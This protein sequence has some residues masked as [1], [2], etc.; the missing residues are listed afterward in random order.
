MGS[1]DNWE[2]KLSLVIKTGDLCRK[3]GHLMTLDNIYVNAN[4]GKRRCK[5]CCEIHYRRK[6]LK[7]NSDYE[8]RAKPT[9]PRTAPKFYNPAWQHI[10]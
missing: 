6:M 3:R 8:A 4:D 1:R 5:K 7:K 9:P 2:T 10:V